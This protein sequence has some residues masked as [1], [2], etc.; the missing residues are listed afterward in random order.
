MN[1]SMF[2]V[3]I[4]AWLFEMQEQRK[5]VCWLLVAIILVFLS[6][7]NVH[8]Q[9][10]EA[11]SLVPYY[12]PPTYYGAEVTY[13]DD[14][15]LFE[16]FPGMEVRQ[17]LYNDVVA[18]LEFY[19]DNALWYAI[20][21][22]NK[23]SSNNTPSYAHFFEPSLISPED[24]FSFKSLYDIDSQDKSSMRTFMPFA[25]VDT[26]LMEEE[27]VELVMALFFNNPNT[28]WDSPQ[29]MNLIKATA[30]GIK[31]ANSIASIPGIDRFIKKVP[32]LG[33]F[34]LKGFKFVNKLGNNK[35]VESI[36]ANLKPF[37]EAIVNYSAVAESLCIALVKIDKE[38]PKW[39]NN[40]WTEQDCAQYFGNGHTLLETIVN[41]LPEPASTLSSN[42]YVNS[43]NKTFASYKAENKINI[44]ESLIS[45]PAI[46]KDVILAFFVKET[47]VDFLWEQENFEE[48]VTNKA[49]LKKTVTKA[50]VT[51]VFVSLSDKETKLSTEELK[52]KKEVISFSVKEFG[53]ALLENIQKDV[54][55]KLSVGN[56]MKKAFG[57]A[58]QII[59]LRASIIEKAQNPD[60]KAVLASTEIIFKQIIADFIELSGEQLS[61]TVM[62]VVKTTLTDLTPLKVFKAGAA[63]AEGTDM[64][65]DYVVSPEV[66]YLSIK[67]EGE[68]LSFKRAAPSLMPVRYLS[69][70]R[71]GADLS[72]VLS[73]SD[74]IQ[75]YAPSGDKVYYISPA[76]SESNLASFLVEGG[77]KASVEN[78]AVVRNEGDKSVLKNF[79]KNK[80][81]K[82]FWHAYRYKFNGEVAENLETPPNVYSRNESN[83]FKGNKNYWEKNLNDDWFVIKSYSRNDYPVLDKFVQDKKIEKDSISYLD[84]S[85][86]Y[87]NTYLTHETHGIYSNSTWFEIGDFSS[88]KVDL[89]ANTFNV[90]VLKDLSQYKD[91]FLKSTCVWEGTSG[92]YL[93]IAPTGIDFSFSGKYY[94]VVK[95]GDK[96]IHPK[97]VFHQRIHLDNVLNTSVYIYEDILR[98]WENNV[99]KGE[100][101]KLQ[102][103]LGKLGSH[104]VSFTLQEEILPCPFND[105]PVNQWYTKPIVELK[106]L[107]IVKGYEDGTF[108]P[109][110]EVTRAEFL[111]MALLASP[112]HKDKDF[113]QTE[114]SFSDVLEEHWASGYIK[115]A[116]DKGIVEGF[117]DDGTFRPNEI[118]T[119]AAAA[120]IV[121]IV[122]DFMPTKSLERI[123]FEK[124][125][126]EL[127]G[128]E[129]ENLLQCPTDFPDV[130]NNEWYCPYIT[131]LWN[132][133]VLIGYWDG[134]FKPHNEMTRAET[135]TVICRAYSYKEVGDTSLCD[136]NED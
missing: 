2:K 33:S 131:A 52:I 63:I 114:T 43:Y 126:Q 56:I 17:R 54:D 94:L 91:D 57:W 72:K 47:M 45:I 19:S 58:N 82:V 21:N 115:Y 13:I 12:E 73:I 125:Q 18:G 11:G 118:I 50:Q 96:W 127:F 76:D 26:R 87:K 38:I 117:R 79:I 98:A 106:E 111:K 39:D 85:K 36:F 71:T 134:T 129:P 83:A 14:P 105:I 123:L 35:K 7:I 100:P 128:I 92:N 8:A 80:K 31:A 28:I 66:V 75:F 25:G 121:A 16:I 119:R 113:Q 49:G 122:F 24:L 78:H 60:W 67:K 61:A 101:E 3:P 112:F 68:Q 93:N 34:T 29:W 22:Q 135:A 55:K 102:S 99:I 132:K 15:T 116:K 51:K 65:W 37:L 136:M 81:G 46:D 6:L 120:K 69:V 1:T 77:F 104:V 23:F 53:E 108:R 59:V 30:I 4:M 42:T 70:K 32:I 133:K 103:L 9:D 110:D 5:T 109:H 86:I 89:Y 90:Y 20:Y 97:E 10:T 41:S 27:N 62:D 74:A 124:I 88:N 130:S 107:G 95:S 64:A 44:L 48:Y 40:N 84:F